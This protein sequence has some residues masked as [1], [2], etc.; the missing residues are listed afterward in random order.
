MEEYQIPAGPSEA[1][2]SDKKSR[3]IGAVYPV[4]SEEEARACIETVRKKH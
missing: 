2:L 1:E 4:E 3:F